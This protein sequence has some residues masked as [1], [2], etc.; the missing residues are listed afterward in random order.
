MGK[1][2][3]MIDEN[4]RKVKGIPS[5]PYADEEDQIA[6]SEVLKTSDWWRNTGTQV[7]LF[8]NEFAEYQDCKKGISAVNGTIAIEIALKAFGI[9]KGDEVIVPA[10]TFYST[11][12]A[13]LSVH[14]IPV[15]VDVLEDTF[16]I[17]PEQIRKAV[18]NKTKV[19]IAVHIAGHVADMEEINDIAKVHGI[20]VIEDAAHAHGA[21]WRGK[22]AG[23]L[24]DCSTFSFQNAK[25]LTAGE[26]GMIL[27]RNEDFLETAFLETNCGRKEG[28]TTYQHVLIGTNARMAELLGA[29]LRVQ[30][31]R[32]E[33]QVQKRIENYQY[34]SELLAAAPGIKLQ[35]IKE[36]M[37]RHSHYMIMFYYDKDE[38]YGASREEFI[39][40]IRAAGIP[41]NRAYESLHRLPI[42]Q[43]LDK[44]KYRIAGRHNGDE[45]SPCC[46]SEKISENVV[47]FGH[48][49]LLGEKKLMS[50]IVSCIED[51]RNYCAEMR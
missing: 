50:D 41:V 21:I 34:L 30:L 15:L 8:E 22:K 37:T 6:V 32:L 48:Q 16:C 27:S 4:I 25:L 35:A 43:K 3:E 2:T 42:F 36:D 12:S 23:S 46:Q 39:Q 19:I 28:D 33:E 38:F 18:T 29:V 17:D 1:N 24:G 9:G 49:I 14:A 31:K 40:Y 7:K 51:F 10:F 44:S 26:G 11:V 47:C 20:K 5:W 13:V 45:A